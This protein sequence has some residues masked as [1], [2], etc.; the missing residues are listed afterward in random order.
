MGCPQGKLD[1]LVLS[2]DPKGNLVRPGIR[3]VF[4]VLAGDKIMDME[5]DAIF[6]KR[7]HYALFIIVHHAL[8]AAEFMG[9][10]GHMPFIITCLYGNHPEGIEAA[11]IYRRH[12]RGI[13]GPLLNEPSRIHL[14]T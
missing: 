10:C 2:H 4:N 13:Q 7:S 1:G 5:D 11:W 14:Y 12:R 6:I 8:S 3:V 9:A